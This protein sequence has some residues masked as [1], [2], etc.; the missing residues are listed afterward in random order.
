MAVSNGVYD[1]VLDKSLNSK[2]NF[3]PDAE[4]TREEASTMIATYLELKDNK[5]NKLPY[6]YDYKEVGPKLV[7]NLLLKKD[8]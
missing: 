3:R 5:I 2:F 8:L 7:W 4:I 1:Y 6:F